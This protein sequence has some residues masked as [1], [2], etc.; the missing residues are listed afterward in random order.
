MPG[1]VG[2]TDHNP[3]GIVIYYNDNTKLEITGQAA[4]LHNKWKNAD[5][6]NVVCVQV[7][8]QGQYQSWRKEKGE[9]GPALNIYNYS[10]ELVQTDF[11]WYNEQTGFYEHG[12]TVPSSVDP[13]DLAFGIW[14]SNEYYMAVYNIAVEP[15][16]KPL[17][18]GGVSPIDPGGLPP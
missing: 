11:Y 16:R 2:P 15:A 4:G 14:T 12:N 3:A 17:G 5:K 9:P 7:F 13:D 18:S 10:Q 6:N 8:E 1:Q